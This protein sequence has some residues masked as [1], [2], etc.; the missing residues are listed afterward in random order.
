MCIS[1]IKGS[2][3]HFYLAADGHTFCKRPQCLSCQ[4]ASFLIINN[5]GVLIARRLSKLLLRFT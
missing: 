5:Y 2:V 4:A 3:I 1:L